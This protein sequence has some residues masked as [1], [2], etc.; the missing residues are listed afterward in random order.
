MENYEVLEKIGEGYFGRVYKVMYKP[1]KRILVWKEID[2]GQ[3]KESEKQ[4]IVNEVNILRDLKHPY[5]V[6]YFDRIIDKNTQ[7]LYLVMEFCEGGDL[8]K[9]I[10]Y[11]KEKNGFIDEDLI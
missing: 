7:K 6:K 2:Y 3:L 4:Q 8:S 11:T 10:K 1:D 5:I 9:L